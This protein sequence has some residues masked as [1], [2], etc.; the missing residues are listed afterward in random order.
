MMATIMI[1]NNCPRV[2]RHREV[3]KVVRISKI[4]ELKPRE[5]VFRSI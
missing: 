4:E 3:Q 2:E 1:M 5:E